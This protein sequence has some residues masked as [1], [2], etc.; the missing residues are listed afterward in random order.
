MSVMSVQTLVVN[1]GFGFA[2]FIASPKTAE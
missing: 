2:K 1:L